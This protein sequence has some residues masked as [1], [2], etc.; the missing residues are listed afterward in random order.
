LLSP[1]VPVVISSTGTPTITSTFTTPIEIEI[2][3]VNII[4]LIGTHTY[5]DELKFYMKSPANTEILFWDQPCA[6]QDNFN[7]NFDDEA[8]SANHPCPPTN[9]LT[10]RPSNPLTPFD[11]QQSDGTWTLKIED[12][13]NG[14]GGSLNSWGLKVCGLKPCDLLV[15]ETSGSGPGSLPEAINC[16]EENDT[17]IISPELAGMTINIGA[18]PLML[19]K[20]VT[21]SSMAPTVNVTGTGTRIFEILPDIEAV[22]SDMVITA[23]TSLA[24]GALLNQGTLTLNNVIIEKN[25][26]IPGAMLIRNAGG[27]LSL[28]GACSINQ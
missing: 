20:N 26:T 8:A 15:T 7:I 3:D 9:G 25:S 22:L 13:A 14:D 10:Y 27:S 1:N 6:H 5:M 12:L 11:G 23:G 21:I 24:G 19:T 18:S 28:E 4:S 16:A 17:I 2:T